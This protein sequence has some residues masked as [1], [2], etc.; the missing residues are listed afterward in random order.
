MVYQG[1]IM[2]RTPVKTFFFGMT[3]ALAAALIAAPA[4]AQTAGQIIIV[5]GVK[6]QAVP[7]TVTTPAPAPY[8]APYVAPATTAVPVTYAA[9]APVGYQAQSAPVAVQPVQTVYSAPVVYPN[10]Q[11]I[12]P[13]VATAIG[14]YALSQW[15]NQGYGYYRRPA[16][17]YGGGHHYR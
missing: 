1:M 9:P 7:A 10:T 6:Y 2:L 8:V 5:D 17:I 12:V 15:F 14:V 13:L 16:H 4:A 11:V 3:A